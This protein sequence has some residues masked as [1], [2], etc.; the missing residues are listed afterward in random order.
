M[1]RAVR[2]KQRLPVTESTVRSKSCSR[3]KEE[4]PASEFGS[5]KGHSSGLESQCKVCATPL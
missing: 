5:H 2:R 1:A 4:K 3:C